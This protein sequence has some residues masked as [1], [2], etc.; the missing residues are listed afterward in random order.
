MIDFQWAWFCST[1][2]PPHLGWDYITVLLKRCAGHLPP[3]SSAP[4][5]RFSSPLLSFMHHI[6]AWTHSHM[7]KHTFTTVSTKKTCTFSQTQAQT[8]CSEVCWNAF[9]VPGCRMRRTVLVLLLP[10]FLLSFIASDKH[11]CMKPDPN[12]LDLIVKPHWER[13]KIRFDHEARW[14]TPVT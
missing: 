13:L 12:T 1:A 2:P 11:N 10:V 5:H 14:I 9:D 7:H 8:V 6:S 4:Y 3:L